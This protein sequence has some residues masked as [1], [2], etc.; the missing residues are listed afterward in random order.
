MA[1]DNGGLGVQCA[2]FFGEISP[3]PSPAG[4]GRMVARWLEMANDN[5]GSGVQCDVL[6]GNLTRRRF[7]VA[8]QAPAL[9]R[10]AFSADGLKGRT[11]SCDVAWCPTESLN[12]ALA[13]KSNPSA[14]R[15]VPTGLRPR[16]VRQR[17]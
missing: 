2:T 10:W 4:R 8:R 17:L 15:F 16:F 13:S 14:R 7:A 3:L 6:R 11:K 5:G 1:N 9:S 12:I